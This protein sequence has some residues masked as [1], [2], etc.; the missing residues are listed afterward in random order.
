MCFGDW[1]SVTVRQELLSLAAL[2]NAAYPRTVRTL[3]NDKGTF[4]YLERELWRS[5][6]DIKREL[7]GLFQLTFTRIPD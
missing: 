5:S 6:R 7:V 3:A 4:V 2:A 1:R